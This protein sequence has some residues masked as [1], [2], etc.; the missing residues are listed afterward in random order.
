MLANSNAWHLRSSCQK[1]LE[2]YQ[3]TTVTVTN[4]ESSSGIIS[5]LSLAKK[6]PL[7]GERSFVA[8]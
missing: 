8:L 4:I 6:D 5:D 3:V 2:I 1:C 7:L